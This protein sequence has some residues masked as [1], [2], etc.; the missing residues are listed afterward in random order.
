MKV[1]LKGP[2]ANSAPITIEELIEQVKYAGLSLETPARRADSAEWST[3]NAFLDLAEPLSVGDSNSPPDSS[4]HPESASVPSQAS[5]RYQCPL[6][7]RQFSA[8]KTSA[9]ARAFCALCTESFTA[10]NLSA[11]PREIGPHD[12][13]SPYVLLNFE[14]VR[15][16]PETVRLDQP[17]DWDHLLGSL[18]RRRRALKAELELNEGKLSWLPELH[19]TDEIVH[20]VLS[21]LDD[22]GWHPHHWAV[23]CMPMLN[24]F[25][26]FGDLDYFHLPENEPYPLLPE[27]APEVSTNSKQEQFVTFISPFFRQRW[28]RAIK[29]A[30]D[31]ENYDGASGLFVARA[32]VTDSD[33]D[34]ALEPVRRHFSK[35]RQA[36]K[37]FEDS[38]EAGGK[39]S[40]D[41]QLE[42][43][44]K[45]AR[46]LNVLPSHL[47]AK[48]RDDVCLGYRSI[49]VA[50]AN[51]RGD[52]TSSDRML[53]AA[54]LF[55][56]SVTVKQR[57]AEDRRAICNLLDSA[58]AEI[59][60]KEQ[61]TLRLRLKS[62]FRERTLE[63]TPEHISWNGSSIA[64]ER[65]DGLRYGITV[66]TTNGI[67][68]GTNSIFAVRDESGAFVFTDWL[69]ENN[70]FGAVRCVMELHAAT[71]YAKIITLIESGREY[72][73]E[74][75]KLNKNGIQFASGFIFQKS[76]TLK[77]DDVMA[78]ISSGEVHV[79]SLSNRKARTSLVCSNA[80]NAC[81]LPTLIEIMKSNSN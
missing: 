65:V 3:V 24:R 70:F 25:L 29:Q 73:I 48:L 56:S 76:H 74:G 75:I 62:W 9:K 45:E 34:D 81:L 57:L 43:A 46:L 4:C 12:Y 68:T 14:A 38:I 37:E 66:K 51:H 61:F 10:P 36:L 30:L 13:V 80:W 23:F 2:L 64:A 40:H 19:I 32:Q 39:E 28:T 17:D 50:L 7:G 71:I 54:E 41:V 33:F 26:M 55:R 5:C 79:I 49:S 77:W 67:K 63:I 16:L 11:K 18:T 44:K 15:D 53:K 47:C 6:C 60:R 31:T 21:E 59:R 52:F 27:F 1:I 72:A 22:S 35:R 78:E 42:L 69:D 20:R 58:Q 8:E